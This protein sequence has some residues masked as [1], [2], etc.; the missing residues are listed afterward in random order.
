MMMIILEY[1]KYK[2]V[3]ARG[4]TPKYSE[5]VFLIRKVKN[6]VLWTYVIKD[7]NVEETVGTFY[8]N[9]LQK[10]NQ[11]K[12]RMEKV[13]KRKGDMIGKAE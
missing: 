7:L 10:A 6:T 4:Y 9:E 12:F 5:E 8:Q 11:N 1:Q 3:F 2:N 13:I